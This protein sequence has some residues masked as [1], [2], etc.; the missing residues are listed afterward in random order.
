M[1]REGGV[2]GEGGVKERIR[3]REQ[4][5]IVEERGRKGGQRGKGLAKRHRYDST[6]LLSQL[7][8]PGRRWCRGIHRHP[9]RRNGDASNDP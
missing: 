1:R 6:L 2:G 5:D 8:R 9:R 3:G 7:A 4:W